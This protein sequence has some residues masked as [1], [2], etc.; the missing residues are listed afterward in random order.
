MNFD[1]LI[2]I[3]FPRFCLQCRRS[4]RAGALCTACIGSIAISRT[5]FCGQCCA[6]L[7]S[8]PC[9][10]A[11]P[12]I[13]GT[14]GNYGD[15]AMKMLIHALKFRGVQAAAEPL[16]DLMATYMV[17][18]ANILRDY[19]V[20]PIPLSAERLRIRGFNQSARIGE[21]FAERLA[22]SFEPDCLVRAR[23]TKPQSNVQG[24]SERQRN[25]HGC[26][27]AP[28]AGA[29]RGKNII[30]IDDVTT[31][32]ATFLEAARALKAAGAGKIVALAAAK[33]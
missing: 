21:R 6:P 8:L 4:L 11:F 12:Y 14:A 19:S 15:P 28:D 3:L 30:L 24:L 25:V 16:A 27:T 18:C 13:L 29:V 5:L 33:A 1:F 32:G 22:L 7:G 23:H 26:F 10:P 17:P 9:H 2:S 31:S 20:V